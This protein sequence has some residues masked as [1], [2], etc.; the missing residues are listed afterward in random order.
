MKTEKT[1]NEQVEAQGLIVNISLMR[2]R[3]GVSAYDFDFLWSKDLEWLRNEQETT[4]KHYN[5]AILNM[6]KEGFLG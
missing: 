2:Q 6:Q 3:I 4:L 5:E 1:F